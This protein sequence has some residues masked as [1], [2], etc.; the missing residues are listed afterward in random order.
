MI[1]YTNYKKLLW[2]LF[3]IKQ[4][5]QQKQQQLRIE[6]KNF[7]KWFNVK[8]IFVWVANGFI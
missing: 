8:W 7:K 3:N 2:F 4:Q 1:K 5:H 6:D